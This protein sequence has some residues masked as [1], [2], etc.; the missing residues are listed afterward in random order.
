MT[1]TDSLSNLA[2]E[3]AVK[4]SPKLPQTLLSWHEDTAALAFLTL[5]LAHQE[6]KDSLRE[7]SAG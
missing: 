4:I 5:S 1:I 7:Y 6:L 3:T 2:E